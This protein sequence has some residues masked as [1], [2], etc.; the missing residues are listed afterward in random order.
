MSPS[1]GGFNGEWA[2]RSVDGK[3]IAFSV[4]T[5]RVTA[6]VVG[7]GFAACDGVADLKDLSVE[8]V[9]LPPPSDGFP[10]QYPTYPTFAYAVGVPEHVG[11]LMVSGNF[12][13]A[14]TAF[15]FVAFKSECGEGATTWTASKL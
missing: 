12:N 1:D 11:F 5:D 3:S 10:A 7:S 14:A 2:G 8:I 9:N 6:I 13:S 15:G 4:R